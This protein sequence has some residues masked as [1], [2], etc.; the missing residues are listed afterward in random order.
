M[1]P[2]TG[3]HDHSRSVVTGR[4]GHDTGE[5]THQGTNN[6]EP[7]DTTSEDSDS[8]KALKGRLGIG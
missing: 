1:A 5:Q 3:G 2:I 4:L 6:H 8:R 7:N